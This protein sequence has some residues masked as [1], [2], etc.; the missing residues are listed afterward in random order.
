MAVALLIKWG[1]CASH[2]KSNRLQLEDDRRSGGILSGIDSN[3]MDSAIV[4]GSVLY[5][6][7]AR[8]KENA[9]MQTTH[10]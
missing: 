6:E 8:R 4:L 1:G 7:A 3:L 5:V 2:D 9:D 10:P